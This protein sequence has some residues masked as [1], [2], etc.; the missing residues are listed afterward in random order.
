MIRMEALHM[1]TQFFFQTFSHYSNNMKKINWSFNRFGKEKAI[2]AFEFG[3]VLSDVAK[4][5]NI[6]LE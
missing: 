3:I 6:A 4:Q 2:L 1:S 5:M